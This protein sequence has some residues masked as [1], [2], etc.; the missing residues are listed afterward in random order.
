MDTNWSRKNR[1]WS[2]LPRKNPGPGEYHHDVG[3]SNRHAY[4][5]PGNRFASAVLEDPAQQKKIRERFPGP[6]TYEAAAL[7]VGH[8]KKILGG[9]LEEIVKDE[10]VPG[11]GA[12]KEKSTLLHDAPGFVIKPA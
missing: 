12:Y 6:G 4:N 10:Q 11:P 2:D 7:K 8:M 3:S 1:N 9:P 5:A